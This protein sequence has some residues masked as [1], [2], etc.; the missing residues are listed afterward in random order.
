MVDTPKD[1]WF[2]LALYAL[3]FALAFDRGFLARAMAT[4][5]LLKLGEWSYAIY[6]G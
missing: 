5:P 4:A 3:I 1:I 2:A 6:M